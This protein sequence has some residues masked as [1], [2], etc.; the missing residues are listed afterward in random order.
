MPRTHAP[1]APLPRAAWRFLIF[2]S[3]S[4]V[5]TGLIYPL[6]AIFLVRERGF[7]PSA[8]GLLLASTAL[9][10]L[11][12][13]PVVGRLLDRYAVRTVMAAGAVLQG[14]GFLAYPLLP[15][16]GIVLACIA[17]GVGNAF[18]YS[19]VPPLVVNVVDGASR[20]RMFAL[21]YLATNLGLGIGAIVGG[22]AADRLGAIAFP[23]LYAADAATFALLAAAL[24]TLPAFKAAP[25]QNA[26]EDRSFRAVVADRR[27]RNLL[28]AQLIT[29]GFCLSQLE[30]AVPLLV[31]SMPGGGATLAGTVI[32]ANTIAVISVQMLVE[33]QSRR[34]RNVTVL[35]SAPA[36]WLASW[37]IFGTAVLLH[38]ALT[39][40]LLIA[41]A[42]VFAV[43]ES[44]YSCSF[45]PYLIDVAGE[46]N[47]ARV[48]AMSSMSWSTGLLL[49]P[50]VGATLAGSLTGP[51]YAAVMMA[52]CLVISILVLSTARGRHRSPYPAPTPARIPAVPTLSEEI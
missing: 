41:F 48:S 47:M 9:T 18:F 19:G 20:S 51:V 5:G 1:Q 40:P 49:G 27:I 37:V 21:R 42:V 4:S 15:R 10:N 14:L 2:F 26:G 50:S 46:N 31:N 24:L 8:A 39:P 22:M 34:H 43:A 45:Q 44:V 6:T 3:L 30:A 13:L 33:R 23:L 16:A 52:G 38:N 28:L 17:I 11:A 35:S 29:V 7:E 32:A 25:P 36:I 12:T